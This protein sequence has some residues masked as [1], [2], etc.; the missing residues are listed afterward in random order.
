MERGY[1]ELHAKSFYSFGVGAS[2]P[3]E[4]LAQAKAY[5]Y[6]SLAL[7]DTNLCGALEFARLANSLGI[8]PI[9]GGELTLTDGSRVTLLAKTRR[10]YA[11]ISRLFTLANAVD[12]R[13]PRLDCRHLPAHAEGIILLTGGRDSC[14]A[15]LALAGQRQKAAAR[16]RE[17]AGWYGPDSVYVE[18][19]RNFLQGDTMRNRKLAGVADEAG[20]P[21][22]ATNDVHY[23]APERYRLQNALV[24]VRLN[25]T[26]DQALPHLRPNDHLYLKPPAEMA[27]LFADFPE[28][29]AN[30]LR[31]AEECSFDLSTDLGYTLP[32]PALPEGYTAESYLKRL[33][34]EAAARRYGSVS[35]RI[36]ERLEEEFSLIGGHGLAGFLLLYREIVL[37]AQGIVEER[38][39]GGEGRELS[40][41]V[42]GR[43]PPGR[44]RGSSVA[45][46]V[47]Y[48]I[49]ISHVDPLKWNLTLERFLSEDMTVLPDIDLDFPR[50]LRDE[51]IERVH[52]Q[53]G[54][55][56]A[57]L[58]GAIFTYKIK[59]VLRDLGKALGLP[60]E[61]L[62]LLSKQMRSHDA[63]RLREEMT[64]LPAFSQRVNA[65]G[66]RE[67]IELAPQLMGAPK[68]LSQHVGGM[69]L[70]SSPLP[71]MVPVRE[72]AIE[73]RFIMDWD[74]DSVADA[75]FAKIDIL[76][77]PVLDQL[78][79]ALDLVELRE[80]K[81]PD[82]SGIDPEDPKV[83][84]MI[85]AGLSKGIFLLQSPAQLKM[86]QRLRS[87]N[88]LDLAY[89]VALIRPGVGV[90]GSAVSQFVER[91]RHGA[92]W[93]YDHP[94]EERALA[95]GYG[96]IVWQE[97]VV[98]LITD[99]TG[100]TA[101]Q[102]DEIRRAF[103]KSNNEHL[104]AL[105]WEQFREGA[106]G[107]GVSEETARRIFAKINGHYM[108]P[109][110]HSHAFAITAFQAAWLKCYYPLEFFVALMNNQPM[111]F[112]PLETLK[113]DARRF[114]V[115]FLNPCI[116]RSQIRCTPES[117]SV[118]MG[119]VFTKD[120]G[121]ASARRIVEE[122]ERHGE[123]VSTGD[124]VRRTGMNDQAVLS[125]ALAGA[126]DGI[127]PNRRQALWEAGLTV[128]PAG[129]GQRALSLLRPDSVAALTDFDAREQ[130]IGE[131]QVLEVYPKGHLMEFVR[132]TLGGHIRSSVEVE[133]LDSGAVVTVAGWPVA[134]QH[135]RGREG[136]VFVTIEDEFGDI[137]IIL[138]ADVFARHSRE[139][140]SQVIEVSG[141]ISKWDGTTNVIVSSL[142][143]IRVGVA[144]P[145]AHDWH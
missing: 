25:T 46:L 9:T 62:S 94:L 2:H 124:L 123:Y 77:L 39:K 90:Q 128:R 97:Q 32:E 78:E 83:Y 101:A 92:E 122:R 120:V 53:F 66:W 5:G 67:L 80:G 70:S 93:E 59:G 134:R 99:V 79:E 65:C 84:D 133:R 131:Y 27:R 127:A 86:G 117:G 112:Y 144:M 34:Y 113:Q 6:G 91:Y 7:T 12:R 42:E 89:Q 73:G 61:E 111:G 81:R 98:Q 54:R 109:E 103:A 45:L 20:I 13:E 130:M 138:W 68:L 115:P 30:T 44:G 57:V 29:V 17:Y 41:V 18:L 107:R 58:A 135:P 110:S 26:I 85:N 56:Y 52:R 126:F 55:E 132:P 121:A 74:K 14:L 60:Q 50:A 75:G 105:H 71:E 95:R 129:N 137:Q 104:I 118:R 1:I 87:R 49:G 96:I 11:N 76:S 141:V 100:L 88:L 119:L 48:L 116:N 19:Q 143:A 10:G 69:I 125:L 139:L 140:D 114:G 38:G 82:L 64:Q 51:L 24:A 40:S 15:R 142:R 23:H 108:F 72:G 16:L 47:G 33:C 3:H 102:A 35:K 145:R 21:L 4:L 63:A 8:R 37:I 106:R 31:I 28:A 36:A 136:T 22:V 43:D